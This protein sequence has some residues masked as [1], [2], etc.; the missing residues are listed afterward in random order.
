MDLT[1]VIPLATEMD[2]A[3]FFARDPSLFHKI[4]MLWF[5]DAQVE[6]NK[7]FTNFP[8]KLLYPVDYF[9][10]NNSAAQAIFDSFISTLEEEFGM[11]RTPINFTKTLND[12]LEDTRITNITAFQLS[13]NRLAEYVSYNQVGVPLAEAWTSAFPDA[14]YPPLDPNPRNAFLRSENLTEEDYDEAVSIKNTF[15]EFWLE[16]MLK[17]DNETCSDG[18]MI[19]DMG[20]GGLPSYREQALNS[21]PGATSL[22]YTAP[23]GGPLIPSNYLASMSGSPQIGMP[24]GQVKY[25]SYIS[26]QEEV[27]P[28]NVDLVAAPGCDGLLLAVLRR[29]TEKGLVKEVKTGRKAF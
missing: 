2:T 21:M 5:E 14:G 29:L 23:G 24:F 25:Q 1:G 6:V 8:S 20:T 19:L 12:K 16:N 13:S 18:I 22:S 28:V 7:T 15:R 3:G 4:S 11:Q 9:P 27:L 17:P 10:L 26:R